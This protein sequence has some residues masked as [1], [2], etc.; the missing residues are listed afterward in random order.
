MNN[1]TMGKQLCNVNLGRLLGIRKPKPA[2]CKNLGFGSA[3]QGFP[4]YLG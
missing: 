2:G 1:P 3:T 4:E